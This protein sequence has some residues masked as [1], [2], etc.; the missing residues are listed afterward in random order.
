[1]QIFNKTILDLKIR[2]MK[3]TDG[4]MKP[5]CR[6]GRGHWAGAALDQDIILSDD[7]TLGMPEG[8]GGVGVVQEE[9]ASRKAQGRPGRGWSRLAG[10]ILSAMGSH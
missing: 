10:F 6:V 4:T 1:M 8:A 3:E 2:A 5:S 7:L 9:K